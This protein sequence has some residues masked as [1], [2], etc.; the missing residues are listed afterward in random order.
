MKTSRGFTL[1]E[2]MVATLIMGIAVTGVMAAIS[3]LGEPEVLFGRGDGG[4]EH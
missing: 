4:L 2:V 3:P 1:L